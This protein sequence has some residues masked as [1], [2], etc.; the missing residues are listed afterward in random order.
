MLVPKVPGAKVIG[1]FRPIALANFQFKIITK[2]LAARLVAIAMRIVSVEQR[3]F[4]K[5]RNIS[6]CVILACEAINCIDRQQI[7]GN[8]ALK[9]DISKAFDTLD[10]EFLIAVLMQFGFSTTF[11]QWIRTIHHS[12]RL[13]ILVNAKVV[14]FF[15][16][17]RG[18]RQGN[19]LSPFVLCL[20]E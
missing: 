5:E 11:I 1:D 12:A 14:G 13:S 10:W 6:E 17:S 3:R 8:I 7:G 2:I 4:I 16:C 20:A 9:V 15:S 18:V 19:P